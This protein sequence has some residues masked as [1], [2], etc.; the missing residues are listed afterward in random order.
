LK[1]ELDIMV[2]LT[3]ARL[4]PIAIVLLISAAAVA[5]VIGV[6]KLGY[7]TV[8]GYPE[9]SSEAAGK[10]EPVAGSDVPRI[11]LSADG[12]EKIGLQTV[13][14]AS[15][16]SAQLS[17]PYAAVF[18]DP[19]GETWVYVGVEDLTFTRQPITVASIDGKNAL[20]S[21]GPPAGTKVVAMGTAQL[22]G[23]EVGVEEE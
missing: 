12:A 10:V 11:V 18:Y 23:I 3:R 1:G 4:G 8:A 21:A 5:G 19:E 7:P 16:A 9:G 13:P 14:I 2:R 20:L 17:I 15:G 6:S 22:Y